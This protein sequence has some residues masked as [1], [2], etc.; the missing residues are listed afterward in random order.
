MRNIN[1]QDVV[2]IILATFF[3]I[4]IAAIFICLGILIIDGA[5]KTDEVIRYKVLDVLDVKQPGEHQAT[6][7]KVLIN[8]HEYIKIETTMH[9]NIIFKHD[10]NCAHCKQHNT[11]VHRHEIFTTGDG[12]TVEIREKVERMKRTTIRREFR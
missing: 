7:Y 8:D 9:N 12:T 5:D 6:Y 10:E 4:I 3:A 11:E 2:A 1:F